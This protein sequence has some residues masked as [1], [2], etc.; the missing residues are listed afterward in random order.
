MHALTERVGQAPLLAQEDREER[1]VTQT[2]Q[3]VGANPFASCF[4]AGSSEDLPIG[5]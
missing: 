1:T 5:E 4:S 2:E 3:D